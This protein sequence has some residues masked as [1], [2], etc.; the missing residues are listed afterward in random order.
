MPDATESDIQSATDIGA[1]GII[2]PTVATSWRKPKGRSN[3]PSY[4]PQ[5]RRSQGNGQ[6]GAL[7]G[8]DYRRTAER[9]NM[10]VVVMIETPIGIANAERSPQC[11]DRCNIRG[12]FRSWKFLRNAPRPKLGG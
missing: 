8:N 2:V 6:S 10:V 9:S 4:P 7:W 1:L 3:G 5:G 11:P 12:Q